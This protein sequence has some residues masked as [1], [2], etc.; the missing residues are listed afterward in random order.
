MTTPHLHPA[1]RPLRTPVTAPSPLQPLPPQPLPP[2]LDAA[3]DPL[4]GTPEHEQLIEE[5]LALKA[6]LK[7]LKDRYEDLTATLRRTVGAGIEH[8]AVRLTL[9][10]SAGVAYDR[11]AFRAAFGDDLTLRC[12]VIDAR[13][14]EQAAVNGDLPREVLDSLGVKVPRTTSVQVTAIKPAGTT[15]RRSRS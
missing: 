14:A 13:Q 1:P 9:R 15:T 4:P 6:R 2:Q 7:P 5:F 10:A 12:S 8:G 11:E 3:A